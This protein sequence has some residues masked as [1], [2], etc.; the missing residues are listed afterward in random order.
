MLSVSGFG[1]TG[2]EAARPGFGKIAEGLSGIVSLTGRPDEVPLHVGFSLADTAA[3]LAGFFAVSMLLYQRDV[4]GGQGAHI[5]IA[6]FEPLLRMA[7]CQ[8]ALAGRRGKAAVREGSNN[9]YGWG[10]SGADHRRQTA[11]RCAD[12]HWVVALLGVAAAREGE[13]ARE[14][15]SLESG[16]ALGYLAKLGLEAAFVHDGATMAKMA[17][18]TQR[19]DVVAVDD[20]QVG[21]IAVPGEVPKGSEGP[22]LPQFRAPGE[23]ED[24]RAVLGP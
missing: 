20:P 10:A 24:R 16:A 21:A 22:P 23:D 9:P 3:G 7:E 2:P 14:V 6:L 8:L 11:L 18:F 5:D 4:Q 19:G 1:Q 17:Y 13:I 12:G 15:A